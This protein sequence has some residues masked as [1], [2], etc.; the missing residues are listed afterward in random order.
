MTAKEYLGQAHRLDMRIRS[1]NEQ[2]ATMNALATKV[3]ST[4]SDMPHSASRNVHKNEDVIVN[5][6]M[7]EHEIQEDMNRLVDLK[8]EIRKVISDVGNDDYRLILEK[9]YLSNERWEEI[10]VD[11]GYSMDHV[12]HMH[13]EA[14]DMVRVPKRN[15]K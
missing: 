15:S 5:I 6:L 13:R 4:L 14:L 2:I 7:L 9:R 3:T 1:L 10:A 12:F 8:R 11:M